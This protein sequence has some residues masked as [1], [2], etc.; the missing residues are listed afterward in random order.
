MVLKE[1]CVNVS[2]ILTTFTFQTLS[3]PACPANGLGWA[4]KSAQKTKVAAAT[5]ITYHFFRD[6][7]EHFIQNIS[8]IEN[9]VTSE[10]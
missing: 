3:K 6:D 9:N 4:L 1:N 10:S 8:H 2:S 7:T 5:A